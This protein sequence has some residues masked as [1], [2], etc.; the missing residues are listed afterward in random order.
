MGSGPSGTPMRFVRNSA[1]GGDCVIDRAFDGANVFIARRSD[2]CV[3]AC[4]VFQLVRAVEHHRVDE[5]RITAHV[6]T[7]AAAADEP[8]DGI[9][10]F[11]IIKKLDA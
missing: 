8:L 5:Q 1:S 3:N 2:S 7:H 10:V 6:G 9:A 11:R 4:E